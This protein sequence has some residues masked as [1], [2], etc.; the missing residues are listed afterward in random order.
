MTIRRQMVLL[1]ALPTLAIYLLAAGLTAAYMHAEARRT[2]ERDMTSLASDCASRFDG[3]LREAARIAETSARAMESAPGI[4]DDEVYALLAKNVEQTEL[5][6]GSCMAFEPGAR[7]AQGVLFA[8][9]VCRNPGG[10]RRMN[11]DQSV[12]DWFRDPQFTW[13]A[14]PKSLGHGVWS[15]PYFDEGAGNILM[16]TYSAPFRTGG[17][18][19]GVNTVDIDLPRLRDTVGRAFDADLDFVIL[20]ADGRFVFHPDPSRIMS[21]T[22]FDLAKERGNAPLAELG[23]TMLAGRPGVGLIDQWDELREQIVS[24]APIGS[25]K[26]VFACRVP[27][28][29]VMADVR[30]RTAW[31]AGALA[32]TLGLIVASIFVVSKRIAGPIAELRNRVREVASGNL[33]V[34][35]EETGQAEEIGDLARGINQMTSNLRAH[36]DRL[37]TE[38]TRLDSTVTEIGAAARQQ[39]AS[40]SAFGSASGQIAAAV[41]AI[42]TTGKDLVRTMASVSENAAETAELAGVGRAGLKGM[43]AVM[44]DLDR[45][46]SSIAEKLGAIE[47]RSQK[48]TTVIT[49]ITKVADRTNILSINAAIEAEKAGTFGAGFLV[50]A[51]EI[52]LLADETAAATLDIEQM[53]Q[54][55]QGAVSSGV[56]EMGRFADQVRCGVRDVASAGSHLTEIIDRVNRSTETFKQVNASMQAQSDGAQQISDAMGSLTAHARQTMRSVQEFGRASTDLQSAVV[57]LRRA[58]TEFKLKG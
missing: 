5:V 24:Y 42:S 28:S 8:P 27:E 14:Q 47:E 38:S 55:M 15:D 53:V 54:Q 11:I 37:A 34:R 51:R 16:S 36:I 25:A 39:E 9:Y 50:I 56:T 19:G 40:A 6:Y 4:S 17:A 43:E 18:F 2:I 23:R 41:Q 20:A 46:T 57:V 7:K 13:Y 44:H 31:G 52:Q 32:L 58:A 12:Y 10:L 48:I 49:T 1:I 29:K 3:H 22:I 26:W 45:A 21:K 30:R 35:I 33:D